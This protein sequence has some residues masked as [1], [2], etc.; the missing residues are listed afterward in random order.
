M[1]SGTARAGENRAECAAKAVSCLHYLSSGRRFTGR[2]FVRD[3]P[4]CCASPPILTVTHRKLFG[5]RENLP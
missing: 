2:F 5:T 1:P 3:F 4:H